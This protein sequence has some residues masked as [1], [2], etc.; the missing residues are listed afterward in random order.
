MN[1][2]R[3]KKEITDWHKLANDSLAEYRHTHLIDSEIALK[4]INKA[5]ILLIRANDQL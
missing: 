3:L 1:D 5:Q 2:T 4:V